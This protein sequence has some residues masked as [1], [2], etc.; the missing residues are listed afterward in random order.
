VFILT[1]VLKES[2]YRKTKDNTMANDEEKTSAVVVRAIPIIWYRPLIFEDFVGLSS[3]A[4][5]TLYYNRFNDGQTVWHHARVDDTGD[6]RRVLGRFQR[7]DGTLS[8][9]GGFL[10]ESEGV[11]CI[12][13]GAEPVWNKYPGPCCWGSD[14]E[15]EDVDW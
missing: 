4:V 12:A 1:H 2:I 15:E 5:M 8:G 11:M 13:S 3:G 9:E 6:R 10:Y 7:E 14:T